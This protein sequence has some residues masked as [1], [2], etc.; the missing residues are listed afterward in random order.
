MEVHI[1]A[2]LAILEAGVVVAG[3]AA[4]CGEVHGLGG[5]GRLHDRSRCDAG[6]AGAGSGIADDVG[7]VCYDAISLLQSNVRASSTACAAVLAGMHAFC[8]LLNLIQ[9]TTLLICESCDWKSFL[10]HRACSHDADLTRFLF[11]YPAAE[12]R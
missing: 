10:C 6:L 2:V 7:A 4:G 9:I 11:E 5:D 12:R 3:G 8:N 1:G